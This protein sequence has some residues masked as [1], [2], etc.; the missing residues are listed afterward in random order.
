MPES[1]NPK[2]AFKPISATPVQPGVEPECMRNRKYGRMRGVWC[3]SFM[4]FNHPR[5]L[6]S[7][8]RLAKG[9]LLGGG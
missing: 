4:F 2:S 5:D 7:T 1:E 6:Y 8:V 3:W 9:N